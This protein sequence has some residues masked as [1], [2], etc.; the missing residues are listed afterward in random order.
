MPQA[1]KTSLNFQNALTVALIL[2]IQI[3]TITIYSRQASAQQTLP[4]ITSRQEMQFD[5]KLAD[6]A[7]T[8]FREP[9]K[10]LITQITT[11]SDSLAYNSELWVKQLYYYSIT[12]MGFADIPYNFLV[13]R[14]GQVYEGRTGGVGAVP[15]LTS[16]EGV[17]LI[18]YLSNGAE[19]TP[20]ARKSISKII[21]SVSSQFALKENQVIPVE[22][23]FVGTK[24]SGPHEE[25][26]EDS[27]DDEEQTDNEEL[28]LS[29]IN[30]TP[31]E[32]TSIL[33]QSL[34][35]F[36]D[37][38]EYSDDKSGLTFSGGV[39]DVVVP[40][41]IDAG[42]IF[43]VSVLLKNEDSYPWYT[44]RDFINLT[45][46]SGNP[47][48]FAID[49]VWDSLSNPTHIE[50]RLIKPGEVAKVDFKMQA[51]FIP[52]EKA[53]ESFKFVYGGGATITGTEFSTDFAIERGDLRLIEITET[54]V[55]WIRVRSC[56]SRSCDELDQ[57]DVGT[58]VVVLEESE[59]WFKI[60]YEGGQE[61]WI[62]GS[63]YKS[64]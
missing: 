53:S 61:G 43:D 32:E 57:L 6:Q 49:G 22:L 48:E 35:A 36:L 14:E 42:E 46:K 20:Q 37:E 30:Y 1:E 17:V 45:T 33:A 56:A 21:E 44:D 47:S 52:T 5:E 62:V 19:I 9:G 28:A 13:D 2:L 58:V 11:A 60:R 27:A 29:K 3:S 64:V 24:I 39:S 41:S 55:G 15:E 34:A 16:S 12:R 8:Q 23:N 25:I 50:N 31:A 7:N 4:T 59:G 38:I 40:D 26:N 18:G 51:G 10:V 63:Y 54:G